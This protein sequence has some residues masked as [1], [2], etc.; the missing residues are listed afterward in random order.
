MRTVEIL[1]RRPEDAEVEHLAR[2]TAE[3][4]QPAEM[5]ILRPEFRE[6]LEMMMSNGIFD[7]NGRL[8][9]LADGDAF[10]DALPVF[11]HSSRFWAEE[12]GEDE[13]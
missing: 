6:G 11:F 1:R 2:I 10:L 13:A 4:G 12:L 9:F 5:E 3:S 8:L 7:D